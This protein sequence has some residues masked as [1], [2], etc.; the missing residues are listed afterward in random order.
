[1]LGWITTWGVRCGIATYSDFLISNLDREVVIL[2]QSDRAPQDDSIRCWERRNGDF[3]QLLMKIDELK[4]KEIMIQH[5]PGLIIFKD[6]SNLLHSLFERG[7]EVSITL[8]NTRSKPLVFRA[9]RI[10]KAAKSLQGCKNVFVHTQADVK[11]LEKM[12][13]S[14]N[15]HHIPHG[16]YPPPK[17]GTEP[18]LKKG[19][20]TLATFGFMMPHKGQPELIEVFKQLK[21]WDELWLLCAEVDTSAIVLE[22]CLELADERVKINTD[23]LDDDVAIATLAQADL[24]VFPYQSTKE[25]ASGAIRM[26]IAAGVPVAVT[27]LEIFSDIKGAIRLPDRSINGMV[28]GILEIDETKLESSKEAIISQRDKQQWSVIGAEIESL[29]G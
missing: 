9:N 4:I 20:K 26:A 17:T 22:K 28:K 25:S 7:I 14:N 18:I 29:L 1:M 8:H 19:G 10:D 5:H 23:F 13:V 2:A 11:R 3:S 27:P 21:D 16:I 12:K 24:V 6:L 15:V